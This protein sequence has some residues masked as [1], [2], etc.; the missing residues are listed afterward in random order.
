MKILTDEHVN[1]ASIYLEVPA[2]GSTRM[3]R[4][5]VI[6]TV[7]EGRLTALELLNVSQ[8]GTLDTDKAELLCAWAREQLGLDRSA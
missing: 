3:I 1:A 7:H 2:H 6:A 4:N 8:H 5:D